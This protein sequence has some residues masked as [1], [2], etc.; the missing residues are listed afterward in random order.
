ME[1]YR[2]VHFRV[3]AA[4]YPHEAQVC[5][6]MCIERRPGVSLSALDILPQTPTRRIVVS[7]RRGQGRSVGGQGVK[8]TASSAQVVRLVVTLTE[9]GRSL[10]YTQIVNSTSSKGT[11]SRPKLGNSL[12]ENFQRKGILNGRISGEGLE[13]Y[14]SCRC[15]VVVVGDEIGGR[16]GL[17]LLSQVSRPLGGVPIE[18]VTWAERLTERAL[19]I[20]ARDENF[21]RRAWRAHP[22]VGAFEPRRSLPNFSR[23]L[24]SSLRE[25]SALRMELM[26]I[27]GLHQLVSFSILSQL[28]VLDRT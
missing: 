15:C 14:S 17:G 8:R 16:E 21:F 26:R 24:Y 2:D 10:R 13:T 22:A 19:K 23:G 1:G 9:A 27:A 18:W 25:S 12:L 28:M 7:I 5:F 11:P 20:S 6:W 3:L 4:G